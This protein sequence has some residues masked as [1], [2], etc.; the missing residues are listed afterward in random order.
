MFDLNTGKQIKC[1]I[2]H[3]D[4][5]TSLDVNRNGNYIFSGGHDGSL[6]CWDMRNFKCVFHTEVIQSTH[7]K[8]H[9]KKYDE[10]IFSVISHPSLPL[11]ATGK[12]IFKLSNRGC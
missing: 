4:A 2:A 9:R 7:S 5:V 3:T 12:L 6:R 8:A 10:A 11:L 1:L